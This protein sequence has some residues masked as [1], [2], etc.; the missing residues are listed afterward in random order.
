[1]PLIAMPLWM[2]RVSNFSLVKWA[3]LG[4]EGAVWRGFGWAEMALPLGIL[5][6]AGLVTFT[7]GAVALSRASS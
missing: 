7:I 6:A 2:Q 5:V 3:I 1:V 4:V